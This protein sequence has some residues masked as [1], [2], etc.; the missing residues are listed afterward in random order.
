MRTPESITRYGPNG[1]PSNKDQSETTLSAYVHTR[2]IEFPERLRNRTFF[3]LCIL[4]RTFLR[5]T[6][7]IVV[8]VLEIDFPPCLHF[9][10]IIIFI[11]THFWNNKTFLKSIINSSPSLLRRVAAAVVL[12]TVFS[13]P[14][15]Y[16]TAAQCITDRSR[17]YQ[18]AFFTDT[19]NTAFSA[20]SSSSFLKSRVEPHTVNRNVKKKIC[21]S[22]TNIYTVIII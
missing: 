15:P 20:P 9:P 8:T 22:L 2:C 5:W 19:Y 18:L 4:M 6:P 17:A 3:F 21:F 12:H 11:V 10:P 7:F 1:T 13:S 16:N 14:I